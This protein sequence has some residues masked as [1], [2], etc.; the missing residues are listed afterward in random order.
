[1]P[2]Y[3]VLVQ[4]VSR[5][6]ALSLSEDGPMLLGTV[7]RLHDKGSVADAE[8]KALSLN[9]R[10]A[11]Q[12]LLEVL[13][14][15]SH[16]RGMNAREI[17]DAISAASP[18]AVADVLASSINIPADQKQAV[19]EETSLERRLRRVLEL[20]R[21]QTRVLSIASKIH[22]EVE[23][24]LNSRH[25]EYYL[26]QQL[27][28]IRSE[29]GEEGGASSEGDEMTALEAKLEAASLP[30][31]ARKVAKRDLAR[32]KR[33]QASQPE[34]TVIRTYLETVSELPWNSMSEEAYDIRRAQLQLD[35][36]HYGLDKV[37]SIRFGRD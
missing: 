31:E 5:I 35:K 24:K 13:K 14:S 37:S 25:R 29:L 19:L 4:G 3:S 26:R 11:A 10:E 27:K 28:A 18:G 8:V 6:R 21:E 17:L 30:E 1:T 15:R 34:Y 12:A 32:L 2:Q 20:V 22:S 33:M 7:V 16:P 23:G 36:D 9:L